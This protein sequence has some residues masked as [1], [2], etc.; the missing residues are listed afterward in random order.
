MKRR[1]RWKED[2][3]NKGKFC[4]GEIS[5][6]IHMQVNGRDSRTSHGVILRECSI[7]IIGSTCKICRKDFKCESDVIVHARW[8]HSKIIESI[9]CD[10]KKN[11]RAIN[12][13]C[14]VC[15]KHTNTNSDLEVYKRHA[16][17]RRRKARR[18]RLVIKIG[19]V[20]MTEIKL[21]RKYLK[22]R[23]NEHFVDEER[24]MDLLKNNEH[25][26]RCSANIDL[27]LPANVVVDDSCIESIRPH[28]ATNRYIVSKFASNRNNTITQLSPMSR[29]LLRISNTPNRNLI[30]AVDNLHENHCDKTDFQANISDCMNNIL[31]RNA[32][33]NT[34]IY[35]KENSQRINVQEEKPEDSTDNS[36]LLKDKIL[37]YSDKMLLCDSK[38]SFVR[39]QGKLNEE[40]VSKQQISS[41]NE[42]HHNST[43]QDDSDISIISVN[44]L[45]GKVKETYSNSNDDD[46]QEILRITR[47]DTTD[48]INHESPNRSEREILAQNIFREMYMPHTRQKTVCSENNDIFKAN[49]N[50]N[51]FE[52]KVKNNKL[53][54]TTLYYQVFEKKLNMFF[55]DLSRYEAKYCKSLT[56]I[57][58]N[59]YE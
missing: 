55:E 18:L 36:L 38:S 5:A 25:Q 35:D 54:K 59:N 49:N 22:I 47:K 51:I 11:K 9:H 2:K 46:V 39:W 12:D 32:A 41:F 29:R 23:D 24:Q 56:E 50:N 58:N 14:D 16:Y 27:S 37:H 28:K 26:D 7:V 3:R 40:S 53:D 13:K 31:T 6:F 4:G 17:K 21:N 52:P 33:D 42:K 15:D 57:N 34:N 48:D 10:H 20:I 8:R 19:G 43:D 30:F 1:S 44:S 45:R